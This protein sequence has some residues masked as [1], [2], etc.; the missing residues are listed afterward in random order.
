MNKKK[1]IFILRT[2]KRVVT[3]REDNVKCGLAIYDN[4]TEG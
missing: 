1:G 3:F 2:S 4:Y